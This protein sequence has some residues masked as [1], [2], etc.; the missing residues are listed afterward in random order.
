MID[1]NNALNTALNAALQ[2]AI[3]Q[4][5]QPLLERIAAL[6]AKA[7]DEC[8]MD[9]SSI[10]FVGAVE[11]IASRVIADEDDAIRSKVEE[12]LDDQD[13]SDR[14]DV[15]DLVRSAVDDLDMEDTVRDA[16]RNLSISISV[17]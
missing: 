10:S 3:E 16:I 17:A 12:V 7:S 2:Q 5:T 13:W 6:E 1:L 8:G 4:A 14:I 15:E 9:L 11:A